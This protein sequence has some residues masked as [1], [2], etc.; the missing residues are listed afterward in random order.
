MQNLNYVAFLWS[1]RIIHEYLNK[2]I[3]FWVCDIGRRILATPTW[4]HGAAAAA[5]GTCRTNPVQLLTANR[6]RGNAVSDN[7]AVSGN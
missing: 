5:H 2:T 1:H 4:W 3:C 7:K 6:I